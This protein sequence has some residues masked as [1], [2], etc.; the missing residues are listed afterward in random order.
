[1]K[2]SAYMLKLTKMIWV[3]IKRK[4]NCRFILLRMRK[5]DPEATN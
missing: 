1:M 4:L 2:Q 5:K 3:D